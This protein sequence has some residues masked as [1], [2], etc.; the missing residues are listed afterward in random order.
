MDRGGDPGRPPRCPH[1]RADFH[2]GAKSAD[3]FLTFSL[4]GFHTV[5]CFIRVTSPSPLFFQHHPDA[6][7]K[8]TQNLAVSAHV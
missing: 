1:L 4:F 6:T 5:S 3:T 8:T 2:V 7:N